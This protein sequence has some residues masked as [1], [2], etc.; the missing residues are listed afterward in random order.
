[1][2]LI[3]YCAR[4]HAL[5]HGKWHLTCKAY[6]GVLGRG[7][8]WGVRALRFSRGFL[9]IARVFV[10]FLRM[11]V[12]LSAALKI[13]ENFLFCLELDPGLIT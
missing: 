8:G 2:K 13:L 6:L 3:K 5:R 7:R 11:Y 4:S 1:M 10:E 9:F 12:E